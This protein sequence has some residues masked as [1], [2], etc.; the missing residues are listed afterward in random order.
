MFRGA[1]QMTNPIVDLVGN[2]T[3]RIIPIYPQSEKAGLNTWEIGDAALEALR[4]SADRGIGDP[5]PASVRAHFRF[6]DRASAWRQ[7]HEPTSMAEAA[8]ARRRLVFDEL[9]RVQLALVM[10]K[11]A[12]EAEMVGTEHNIDGELV[13]RLLARL[14]FKPTGA[15]DRTIAEI[16]HDMA[17]PHPMHRL[18]QGDVGAGKTLVAFERVARGR[19]RRAPGRFDGADRGVG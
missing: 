10:R 6:I 17:A 11:R 18:L 5:V 3:G 8:E 19:A 1:S 16:K 9:L 15:Q 7:I 12:L 14:P 13:P 2:K 4:R